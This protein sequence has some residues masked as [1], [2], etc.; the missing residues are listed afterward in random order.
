MIEGLAQPIL[1]EPY[2]LAQHPEQR[3]VRRH[4]F[5]ERGNEFQLAIGAHC[6]LD[7]LL[8]ADRGDNTGLRGSHDPR[9]AGLVRESLSLVRVHAIKQRARVLADEFDQRRDSQRLPDVLYVDD[10]H[11]DARKNEQERGH[12]RDAGHVASAVTVVC[13]LAQGEDRVHERRDE[14]TN[15]KLARL[16]AQDALHDAR[17]KLAHRELNDDH[18]DRQ[19]ERRQAHH[20]GSDSRKNRRRGVGPADHAPRERVVRKRRSRAIVPKEI[21]AP[22]ST[23]NTGTNQRLAR[24]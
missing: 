2:R 23:H 22:A 6:F 8:R 11:R 3:C 18:R 14:Q 13:H 20:R 9:F 4:E 10:E 19:H 15:R 5:P 21:A 24:R 1:I 7:E 17:R 12:D 16:V